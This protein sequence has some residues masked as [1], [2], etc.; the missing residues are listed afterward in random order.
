[1]QS[2]QQASATTAS[3]N[4]SYLNQRGFSQV[5]EVKVVDKRSTVQ[6]GALS[7]VI[8]NNS[9]NSTGFKSGFT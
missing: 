6:H 4:N 7:D 5:S 2:A 9:F 1:V 8:D 3:V